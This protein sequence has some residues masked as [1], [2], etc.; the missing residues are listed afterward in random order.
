MFYYIPK[1]KISKQHF[2]CHLSNTQNNN[3]NK[4]SKHPKEKKFY[5]PGEVTSDTPKVWHQAESYY[6]SPTANCVEHVIAD[7]VAVYYSQSINV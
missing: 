3:N 4:N 5:T 7:N 1:D 2:L 6:K